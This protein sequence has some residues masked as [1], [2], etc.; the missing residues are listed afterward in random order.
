[1][2]TV[3][4]ESNLQTVSR[5][6]L[7][8]Y[9]PDLLNTFLHKGHSKFFSPRISDCALV[10]FGQKP[11]TLKKD[12]RARSIAGRTSLWYPD[13]N[14]HYIKDDGFIF[15]KDLVFSFGIGHGS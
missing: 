11:M 10:Y 8:G 6:S 12:I 15:E 14:L 13:Q 2:H 1:M 7:V 9:M 4:D 5:L 3:A